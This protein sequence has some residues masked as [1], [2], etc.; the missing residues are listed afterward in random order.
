MGVFVQVQHLDVV[1]LDVEVLVDRLQV[2]ADANVILKLD[3]DGLV[4]ERFEEAMNCMSVQVMGL[5]LRIGR[6]YLKKSMVGEG[7]PSQADGERARARERESGD[8]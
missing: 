3:C 6:R 8:N 5:D 7:P 2:S 4:G 1:E